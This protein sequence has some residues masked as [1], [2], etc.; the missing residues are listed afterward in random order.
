[1]RVGSRYVNPTGYSNFGSSFLSCEK[2]SELIV[3]KLFVDSKPYSDELKRLML[4]NTKDC[5]DDRTNPAYIEKIKNTSI[6]DMVEQE[7]IRFRPKL[8][9]EENSE[10]KSYLIIS[11]DD[12]T[13][14]SANDHYRDCVIEI[15]IICHTDYWNLGA[16][17]QRP[18][19]IMGYVDGILN[20][21]QLTGIGRL[22]FIGSS[23]IILNQELSGYCLLYRSVHGDDDGIP[24]ND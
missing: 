14:N 10:V 7:Y 6:S 2:D 3:K 16:F 12:F 18:F 4:I 24:I 5:L 20:K 23:E 15:D 9:L 17:R 13:S 21:A 8:E 1:M 11:F 22:E 19:K